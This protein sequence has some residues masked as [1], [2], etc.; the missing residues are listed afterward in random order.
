MSE[1]KIIQIFFIVLCF[2]HKNLCHIFFLN[3]LLFV[4]IKIY[5]PIIYLY[6][7]HIIYIFIYSTSNIFYLAEFKVDHEMYNFCK[8]IWHK[9]F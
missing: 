5:L 1:D 8:N 4:L 9:M 6:I 2:L 3:Y 7:K